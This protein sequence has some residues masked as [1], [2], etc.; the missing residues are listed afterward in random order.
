LQYTGLPSVGLKG[1]CVSFLQSAHVVGN[2]SLS[3]DDMVFGVSSWVL[4]V[5]MTVG[6][7]HGIE[8]ANFV[9]S[10]QERMQRMKDF[11]SNIQS[12]RTWKKNASCVVVKTTS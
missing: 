11:I 9:F 5:H 4:T 3:I 8:T 6:T 2:I 7:L 12:I 10:R 1:T